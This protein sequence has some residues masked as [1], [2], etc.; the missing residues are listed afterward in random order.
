[1]VKHAASF[2]PVELSRREKRDLQREISRVR[3]DQKP[4]RT[5]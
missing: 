3:Q 4:V 1:M 2:T 5:S